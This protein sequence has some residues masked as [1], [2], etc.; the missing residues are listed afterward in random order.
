MEAHER[1]TAA[2]RF[3]DR[4]CGLTP[5]QFGAGQ[6]RIIAT[7][8]SDPIEADQVAAL[9]AKSDPATT[10]AYGRDLYAADLR[11][12]RAGAAQTR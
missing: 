6:Q 7:M 12:D 9:A 8:V 11:R 4:V 2:N 3:F 10:A 5:A 1:K